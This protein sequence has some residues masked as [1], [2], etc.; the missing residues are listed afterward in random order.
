MVLYIVLY[1]A[2]YVNLDTPYSLLNASSGEQENK[3]FDFVKHKYYNVWDYDMI[4]SD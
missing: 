2:L 4:D 1:E 3:C